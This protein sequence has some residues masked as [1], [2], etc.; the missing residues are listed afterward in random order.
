MAWVN[1]TLAR[2]AD[3][4]FVLLG[5]LPP[6]LGLLVVSAAT[7]GAML[8]V[9]ARTSNQ[10]GMA[11]AKRAMQA[12]LFE[13]RLF[14]DDLGAI[15]RA[16]GEVL[17]Q[18]LRYLGYSLV[19]LAWMAL[20]LV[21]LI[22]QLQAYYG[23]DGLTAGRPVLVKADLR[24]APGADGHARP[25]PVLDAPASIRIETPAVRLT[26]SNE[27]LW[28]IVPTTTGAFTLTIRH[29]ERAA[30]KTVLVSSGPARRSPFRVS[31]GLMDQLLY[32]SEP[33]LPADSP[34]SLISVAYP[35]P[36]VSIAGWRVHWLI[37]F[38]VLSMGA[39]FVLARRWGVTL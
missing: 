20:P 39:A 36:G 19:P 22:A 7:G 17:R 37:P 25:A 13:I 26:G 8:L 9:V 5:P 28:R 34:V 2:V 4:A 10:P 21:L 35:E 38:V 24:D 32:P 23:Y 29:G 33:P 12:G 16:L 14:H 27:V 15:L 18:N 31:P 30:T 1:A 6:W 3:A 11:A